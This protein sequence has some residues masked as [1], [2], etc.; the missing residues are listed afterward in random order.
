M[1]NQ[2]N[3]KLYYCENFA[4]ALIAYRQS[5]IPVLADIQGDMIIVSGASIPD[6]SEKLNLLNFVYRQLDGINQFL[7]TYVT[8]DLSLDDSYP[9]TYDAVE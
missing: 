9:P 5:L 2:E 3:K 6:Y 7:P 1:E 4:K 8:S